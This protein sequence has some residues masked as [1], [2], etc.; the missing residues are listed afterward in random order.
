MAHF[1]KNVS[2][3]FTYFRYI[4]LLIIVIIV[5]RRDFIFQVFLG[6]FGNVEGLIVVGRWIRL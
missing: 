4:L 3:L 5:K 2:K 6:T 1:D